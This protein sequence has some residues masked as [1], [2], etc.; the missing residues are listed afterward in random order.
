MAL[1][2]VGLGNIGP[3][4]AHT[5]HNVGFDVLDAWAKASNARFTNLR[6]GAVTEIV[7]KGKRF[8]LLKPSTYV[9]LSGKA[10][11]YWLRAERFAMED[12]LVVV[13]DLAL[14]FGALRMRRQGSDGGHNGLKNIN[15]IIGH[16]NYARL[17]VGIGNSFLQGQQ[18]DYVLSEWNDEEQKMLPGVLDRAIDAIKAFGLTGVER[19]MN[20]FNSLPPEPR[21]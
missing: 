20:A 15:E 14:P 18:V 21:T 8:M 2:I 17:R 12:L 11:N 3:E 4:Y 10:V 16:G 9:N 6:Y 1:L 5:R 7:L 13:D 19:A